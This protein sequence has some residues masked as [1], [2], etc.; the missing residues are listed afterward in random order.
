MQPS[1]IA[2]VHGRLQ[3][4]ALS[5]LPAPLPATLYT[6][7]AAHL[8]QGDE[9]DSLLAAYVLIAPD[10]EDN[11]HTQTTPEDSESSHALRLSLPGGK[12]GQM[13][14]LKGILPRAIPFIRDALS[15]DASIVVACESGKDVSAG[16]IVAALQLF[17]QDDGQL[18]LTRS[19][20]RVCCPDYGDDPPSCF[21]RDERLHSHA[22][23]MDHLQ[24]ATSQPIAHHSETCQRVPA[25]S[26]I[27]SRVT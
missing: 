15:R 17:F 1:P 25:Q 27:V 18:C 12:R 22:P 2:H 24:S 3:L 14:F 6:S 21:S 5:E 19:Q 4:C 26:A 16:I 11:L 8:V 7:T 10:S 9:Q 23:P 13:A 20:T